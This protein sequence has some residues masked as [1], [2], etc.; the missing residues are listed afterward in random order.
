M[1]TMAAYGVVLGAAL[2]LAPLLW[3]GAD[4]ADQHSQWLDRAP[5][6][7]PAAVRGE[8]FAQAKLGAIYYHEQMYADALRWLDLATDQG[9][10]WGTVLLGL[11]YEEGKG[12]RQN[13]DTAVVLYMT[14]AKDG[15]VVGQFLLGLAYRKGAGVEQDLDLAVSMIS[16]LAQQGMKPAQTELADM[17]YEGDGVPQDHLKAYEW[18][19][20]AAQQGYF[21]ESFW[22]REY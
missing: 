8:P 17:Y 4:K 22:Q 6:L 15:N 14:A 19:M 12:V 5:E 1:R 13:H 21:A 11:M 9:D 10:P 16:K 18:E 3:L 7:L 2:L 20:K